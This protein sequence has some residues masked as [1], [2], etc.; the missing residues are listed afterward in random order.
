[1]TP[2]NTCGADRT[3]IAGSSTWAPRDL[4]GARIRHGVGIARSGMR[5]PWSSL[6]IGWF[7]GEMS[8]PSKLLRKDA[9]LLPI[10]ETEPRSARRSRGVS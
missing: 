5:R 10:S 2:P 1:M 9:L 3:L 7:G 4:F 8:L 6:R